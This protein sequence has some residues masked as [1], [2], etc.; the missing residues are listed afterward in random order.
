M[1]KRKLDAHRPRTHKKLAG[2]KDHLT[3]YNTVKSEKDPARSRGRAASE[4]KRAK[5]VQNRDVKDRLENFSQ[6]KA[7]LWIPCE[8]VNASLPS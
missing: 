2:D 1:N 3:T 4:T 6:M 5:D 8:C 7:R